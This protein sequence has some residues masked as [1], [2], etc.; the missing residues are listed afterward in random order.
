LLPLSLSDP[1]F[2]ISFGCPSAT[3]FDPLTFSFGKSLLTCPL[4]EVPKINIVRKVK[5]CVCKK[6]FFIVQIVIDVFLSFCRFGCR[7]AMT[8]KVERVYEVVAI[9]KHAVS[10]N[11]KSKIAIY[12]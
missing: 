7:S 4:Q 6:Y 5:T 9:E 2:F 12:S 10:I 11:H 1:R 8:A 3:I